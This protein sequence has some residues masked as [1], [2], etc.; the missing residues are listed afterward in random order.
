MSRV[1]IFITR[2]YKQL[3]LL[4]KVLFGLYFVII[5]PNIYV[6][7]KI[8]ASEIYDKGLGNFII[9]STHMLFALF[10]ILVFLI[11]GATEFAYY[12]AR[13]YIALT[14]NLKDSNQQK[15]LLN[16]LFSGRFKENQHLF[17]LMYIMLTF[18]LLSLVLPVIFLFLKNFAFI[19]D[20]SAGLI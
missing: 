7:S 3:L 5:I 9:I 4:S 8:L 17:N 10:M 6:M 15:S 16:F 12:A 19:G 2:H 1:Y 14:G 13:Q 18:Q 11:K 20:S